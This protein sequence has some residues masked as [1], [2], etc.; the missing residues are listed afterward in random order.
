MLSKEHVDRSRI[1]ST[2]SN[3]NRVTLPQLCHWWVSGLDTA[4]YPRITWAGRWAL[5]RAVIIV[6]DVTTSPA[7]A[8]LVASLGGA[9]P[10]LW[11]KARER[12]DEVPGLAVPAVAG[13]VAGGCVPA[14]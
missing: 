9:A 2:A 10:G 14:A 13:L 7:D 1:A 3:Y 11:E 6:S 4:R 5:R 8:G 12:C